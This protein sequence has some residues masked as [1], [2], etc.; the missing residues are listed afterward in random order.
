MFQHILGNVQI[1]ALIF[2]R[3]FLKIFTPHIADN[4]SKRVIG[5]KLR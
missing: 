1:D 3:E 4:T 5:K 2:E